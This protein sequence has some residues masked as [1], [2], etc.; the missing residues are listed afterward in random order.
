M[1]RVTA[2]PVAFARL[3]P[4]QRKRPVVFEQLE[5]IQRVYLLALLGCFAVMG[6]LIA[7]IVPPHE[8]G[9]K[10]NI[11]LHF[12]SGTMVSV[13]DAKISWLIVV[14]A[15]ISGAA[16]TVRFRKWFQPDTDMYLHYM[17]PVVTSL[18]MVDVLALSRVSDGHLLVMSAVTA[19]FVS[20]AEHVGLYVNESKGGQWLAA[21]M[22]AV[23]IGGWAAL[24]EVAWYTAV[25]SEHHIGSETPNYVIPTLAVA[26]S[27]LVLTKFGHLVMLYGSNAMRHPVRREAALAGMHVALLATVGF[28]PML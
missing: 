23:A 11:G 19:Y 17:E 21:W 13:D 28:V 5:P 2:K 24:L 10:P 18:V 22:H 27:L 7:L 4:I 16:Y 3:E 20:L 6:I 12:D 9:P 8:K 14:A 25:W 1:A 15:A 26:T